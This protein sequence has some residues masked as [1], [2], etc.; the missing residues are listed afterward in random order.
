LFLQETDAGIVGTL[1]YSTDLF[2][3]STVSRWAEYLQHA[4]EAMTQDPRR[5]VSTLPLQDE[6]TA[7]ALLKELNPAP[8]P[9]LPAG[10]T[11]HRRFE[12]QAA[13]LP[14][15]IAVESDG[16]R[17]SFAELNA[18]ANRLARYLRACGVTAG[19]RVPV[20]IPR[21]IDMLVAQ[22]ALLK[23][24]CSYVPIDP[25]TPL[26]RRATILQDC[27]A[28][29]AITAAGV[30]RDGTLT[31]IDPAEAREA[32][33]AHAHTDLPDALIPP[34]PA[35]VMYTSGSTGAPKGVVV[36]QRAVLSL[37]V[38]NDYV[39]IEPHPPSKSGRRC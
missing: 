29:A 21:S 2:E 7:V 8:P 4:V 16:E 1:N 10:A 11:I 15:A 37:C 6:A 27:G 39:A 35:Y 18:R 25:D 36:S 32:I 28:T 19:S 30:E 23:A 24:G 38:G 13:C 17:L 12:L 5:L 3:H 34:P 22:I 9:P 14:Q 20:L 31:W 33:A 26:E